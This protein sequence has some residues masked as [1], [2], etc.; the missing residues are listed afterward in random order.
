[1]EFAAVLQ[2]DFVKLFQ[3]RDEWAQIRELIPQTTLQKCETTNGFSALLRAKLKQNRQLK[4]KFKKY[5]LNHNCQHFISLRHHPPPTLEIW[6]HEKSKGKESHSQK[7][8]C[9]EKKHFLRDFPLEIF[10]WKKKIAMHM[11]EMNWKF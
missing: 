5:D 6:I 10:F 4:Q 3:F 7:L 1:M 9:N 8:L 2:C 11:I